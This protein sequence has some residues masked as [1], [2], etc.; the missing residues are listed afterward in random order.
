MAG[1]AVVIFGA[2]GGIGKCVSASARSQGCRLRLAGR[3]AN[4]LYLLTH[5]PLPNGIRGKMKT[6]GWK[7]ADRI[8]RPFTFI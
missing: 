2:Y 7:F 3:N 8:E 6:C 1:E 4:K 5:A